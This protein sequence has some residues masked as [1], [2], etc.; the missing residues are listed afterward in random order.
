MPQ[1]KSNETLISIGSIILR[2]LLQ[3]ICNAHAITQLRDN[4]EETASVGTFSREQIRYATAI[5][6]RV[7][8]LNHS[9]NS[10]VL[11][12]YIDDSS[13]IVVK[14]ARS[15]PANNEIYNCYGPHYLKMSLFERQQSLLDQY[16]FHC[17]C[18][19]CTSQ[20]SQ[21]DK[22]KLA[23]KCEKCQ[24]SE[25]LIKF[26]E[27]NLLIKCEKCQHSLG[28]NELNLVFSQIDLD[29]N[30]AFDS[31]FEEKILNLKKRANK[32]LMIDGK[33]QVG[34]IQ[35]DE[36]SRGFYM[37]YSKLLDIQCRHWCNLLEF[38]KASDLGEKNVKLLKLIHKNE[39][40]VVELAHELFKLAEIQSN[41]RLYK[42]ALANVNEAI[43]I[44]ESL[45]SADNKILREFLELKNNLQSVL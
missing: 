44:G 26:S 34:N 21:V 39:T 20:M 22:T 11:S 40:V 45:Y 43:F 28:Y 12:S 13:T 2:H 15:I 38:V 14:A 18:D 27:K 17:D 41:C 23:L 1:P 35:I 3:T 4:N 10:N 36:H 7:S 33:D 16:R 30:N 32:Y 9:C 25:T 6:P 8:L 5:Y 19:P 24:S 42:K 29:L 31:N 37:V